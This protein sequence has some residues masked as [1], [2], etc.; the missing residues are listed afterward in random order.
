[1]GRLFW[2]YAAGRSASILGDGFGTIAMG[3][4]VYDL[5]G[6]MLATGTLWLI[7]MFP[8]ILIRLFGA[9][10]L[11]RLNRIRLM[12]SLDFLRFAAYIAPVLLAMTGHLEIWHLYALRIVSGAAAALYHPAAI[13][14]VPSLVEQKDLMRANALLNGIF[15]ATRMA[16]PLLAGV[17][18]IFT[19]TQGAL[20]VDAVTYGI[21]GLT[22]VML[23]ARIGQVSRRPAPN[24]SYLRELADGFRFFGQ[25]PALLVLT[26]MLGITYVSAWAIFAMHAPYAIEHLGA[27]TTVVGAMQACW[28]LGFL[29]GSL[30]I[31]Y[32]GDTRHRSTLSLVGLI[33]VGAALIGLGITPPG[34]IWL[35]LAFKVLEGASFALFTN[36]ST[37]IFQRMVPDELR[38]RVMSVRMLLAWGGNPLG[39]FLGAFLGERIGLPS[40]F[41]LMG[42]VPVIVGLAGF[43]L[44]M[45]RSVDGE[46]KPLEA[47]A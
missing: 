23:P 3:W 43:L 22:L 30:A 41:L 25:V 16:G 21:S 27:D 6:S 13:A 9:P 5:S 14:V 17:A 24:S 32:V 34:G 36:I 39:A 18:I 7:G 38:G 31:S 10:L 35:A 12:A 19:G 40:T 8:E 15:E 20:A 46:L 42:L 28:P 4:L 33:G 37:T 2:Y 45:L 47:A 44:P 1:M 26:V 29:L 11:D